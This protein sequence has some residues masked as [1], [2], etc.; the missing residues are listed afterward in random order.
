MCKVNTII[1]QSETNAP[2]CNLKKSGS[3][4][5]E[6]CNICVLPE[7]TCDENLC[8]NFNLCF[9][10]NGAIC[11]GSHSEATSKVQES[12]TIFAVSF[13]KQTIVG[14]IMRLSCHEMVMI[15]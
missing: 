13:V 10:C 12:Q 7:K 15:I 14:N 4:K 6:K 8:T 2:K 5:V 9:G 1:S 11:L 3:L